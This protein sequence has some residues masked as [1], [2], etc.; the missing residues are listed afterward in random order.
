MSSKAALPMDVPI[1]EQD[2]LGGFLLTH[3]IPKIA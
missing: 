2:V 3:P 1:G